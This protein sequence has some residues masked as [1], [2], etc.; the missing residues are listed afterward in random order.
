MKAGPVFDQS[1]PQWP[2]R[3]GLVLLFV[4]ISHLLGWE[5]L[6]FLTSE[7]ILRASASV[8]MAAT[9]VSFDTIALQGELFQF[10]VSCTFVDVFAG[11]I[12][13]LWDR[14]QSLRRNLAYV[15]I[16]ALA[17]PAFNVI[18]LEI[19]QLLYWRGIPWVWAHQ[20]LGGWAYF[21]VW[22]VIW[23]RRGWRPLPSRASWS[24]LPA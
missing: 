19:G 14:R 3:A 13:L 21:A 11:S 9:R 20:F 22:L 18:R 1:R 7:A 23:R 12:P 8:G 16:A 17:L 6:R 4:V 10:A 15:A 5:W 2:W 24:P